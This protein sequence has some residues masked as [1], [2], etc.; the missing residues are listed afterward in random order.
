[1]ENLN[2]KTDCPATE[3]TA[4]EQMSTN[5]DNIIYNYTDFRKANDEYSLD[6]YNIVIRESMQ[7]TIAYGERTVSLLKSLIDEWSHIL[8]GRL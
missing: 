1:M 7:L 5:L 3:E 6:M 8:F 4:V 2:Q